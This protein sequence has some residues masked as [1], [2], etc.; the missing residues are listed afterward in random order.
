MMTQ[1]IISVPEY[2]YMTTR[3]TGKGTNQKNTGW[4]LEL[5]TP[6]P[7]SN[8]PT[9][10]YITR[11]PEILIYKDID[12]AQVSVKHSRTEPDGSTTDWKSN[13]VEVGDVV[14]VRLV[15]GTF[16]PT[17]MDGIT[18]NDPNVSYSYFWNLESIVPSTGQVMTG[19]AP[20]PPPAGTA[21]APPAGTPPPFKVEG[22]VR[23]HCENVIAQL[24][25]ARLLPGIEAEDG[26]IDWQVFRTYR[27]L[28]FHN[29]SDVPIEPLVL[30]EADEEGEPT[31]G[32]V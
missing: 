10:I 27:D 12:G 29:I 20:P 18:P 26:G 30:E 13:I 22:I 21:S 11:N 9:S 6:L 19:G 5:Q 1:P 14:E 2:L 28:Y 32:N 24:A 17:K 3:V 15:R 8:R 25:I 23:G 31:D 4:V 16:K 7:G